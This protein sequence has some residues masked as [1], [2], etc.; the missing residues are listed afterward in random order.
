MKRVGERF[1]PPCESFEVPENDQTLNL[2]YSNPA[3]MMH[4]GDNNSDG[5]DD[6]D[7]DE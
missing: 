4:G 5:F 7:V 6:G 3:L 1:N 2:D